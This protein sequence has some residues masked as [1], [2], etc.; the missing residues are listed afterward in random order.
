MGAGEPEVERHNCTGPNCIETLLTDV[1]QPLR[2][3]PSR[4]RNVLARK[5][6]ERR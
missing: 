3:P 5:P 4:W 1:D 6:E 2:T